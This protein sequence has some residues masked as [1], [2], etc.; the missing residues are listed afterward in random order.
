MKFTVV[1]DI[2][3]T[4]TIPIT[5]CDVTIDWGD[6]SPKEIVA[7]D[8]PSHSYSTGT[9]HVDIE[10]TVDSFSGIDADDTFRSAVRRK[11]EV[12]EHGFKTLNFYGCLYITR[13]EFPNTQWGSTIEDMTGFLGGMRTTVAV[14]GFNLFD[15][16]SLKSME[17]F[18]EPGGIIRTQDYDEL[19]ASLAGQG[20]SNLK[21]DMGVSL[22]TDKASRDALLANGCTIVDGG[23]R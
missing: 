13:L 2:D 6:G 4:L 7:S 18:M 12:G 19:L 21:M 17:S 14:P 3:S 10:G 11:V 5:N 9:Y 8:F 20:V 1:F 16:G 22:Y 23:E 15:A